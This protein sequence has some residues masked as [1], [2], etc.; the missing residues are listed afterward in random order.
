MIMKKILLILLLGMVGFFGGCQDKQKKDASDLGG[1]KM[2]DLVPAKI[3][4]PKKTVIDLSVHVFE[5]SADNVEG[6]SMLWEGL[7]RT[8]VRLANPRTFSANGFAAG[9]GEGAMIESAISFFHGLGAK[10]VDSYLMR[11]TEGMSEDIFIGVLNGQRDVF[12]TSIDGAM[13][14]ST[15]GPG[16]VVVRVNANAMAGYRDRCVVN[17][18]PMFLP[19]GGSGL[20]EMAQM[21]RAE[22]LYFKAVA[23]ELVMARGDFFC[24]GPSRYNT[25]GIA[26][27][28]LVFNVH[29]PVEKVRF[30]VIMCNGI[31]SSN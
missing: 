21:E 5:L 22:Q 13:A 25:S 3:E 4:V 8:P 19:P 31:S 6:L 27:S 14:G 20:P 1:I 24:Y 29:G 17:F 10:E 16:A 7:Y 12:Y 9:M 26:L 18:A 15:I 2:G 23:A 30:Y 11:V 28:N